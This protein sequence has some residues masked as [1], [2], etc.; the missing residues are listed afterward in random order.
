MKDFSYY[1]ISTN[2]IVLAFYAYSFRKGVNLKIILVPMIMITTKFEV[3]FLNFED[4]DP[5][6]HIFRNN[7]DKETF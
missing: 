6:K 1:Y 5:R 7:L 4:Y 2:I 3:R